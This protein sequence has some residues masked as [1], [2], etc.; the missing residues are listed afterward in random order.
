MSP[1]KAWI[2][3]LRVNGYLSPD[4]IIEPKRMLCFAAKWTDDPKVFFF[5]QWHDGRK[6][7]IQK[8]WDLLH[9][10]DVIVHYNG[11][12]FDVPYIQTEFILESLTPPSPFRQVDLYKTVKKRFAFMSNKLDEV[13]KALETLTKVEHEG[14]GLWPKVMSQ[15]PEACVKMRRYNIGDVEATE[16]LFNKL[17][18]WIPGL[19]DPS[20]YDEEPKCTCG[21]NVFLQDD[22]AYTATGKFERSLCVKCGRWWRGMKRIS[23]ADLREAAL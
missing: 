22:F 19:P 3:D 9:E 14:F 5:S 17:L 12:S 13:A 16:V 8:A 1:A 21:G 2:W 23:T 4:K 6:K 18:P 7:M 10:A 20:L 11:Q 15:V